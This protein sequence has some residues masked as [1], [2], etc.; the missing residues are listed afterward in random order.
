MMN[1]ALRNARDSLPRNKMSTAIGNT[2]NLQC[3]MFSSDSYVAIYFYLKNSAVF[4]YD[5]HIY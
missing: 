4:V 3:F 1:V 5:V 2:Q